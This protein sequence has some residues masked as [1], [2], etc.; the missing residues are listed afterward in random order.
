LKR[1]FC[2]AL[3]ILHLLNVAGCYWIFYAFQKRSK[4][5]L[6]QRLDTDSYAG[7]QAITIKLP[8]SGVPKSENSNYERVDGEFL[9]EGVTY[10]LVKQKFYQ[11][12]AYIVCYKDDKTIT[13]KEALKDYVDT[14]TDTPSEKKAEGHTAFSVVKDL[15]HND[16]ASPTKTLVEMNSAGSLTPYLYPDHE[17][18]GL[19][20]E[21]P[22]ELIS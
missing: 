17:R 20:I 15:L 13:L 5:E 16:K 7:S 14:F 11:D 18:H 2:I 1:F 21:H 6:A 9:Y 4:H 12:T 3:I 22:P 19:A 8:V 10:R